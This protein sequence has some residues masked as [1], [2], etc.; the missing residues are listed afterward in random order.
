MRHM[1][2]KRIMETRYLLGQTIILYETSGNYDLIQ[3]HIPPRT[4]GPPPHLH[5]SI[6][7][8]IMIIEGELEIAIFDDVRILKAGESID[9]PVNTV[10]TFNNKSTEDCKFLSIH[11]PKGFGNFFRKFGIPRDEPSALKRSM[12]PNTIDEI[13]KTANDFDMEIRL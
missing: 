2:H 9:I 12:D 13:I 3:I 1:S 5:K 11:D 4:Q 6:T 7:E 8:F 10:H